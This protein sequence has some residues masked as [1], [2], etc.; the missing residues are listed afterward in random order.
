MERDFIVLLS[1]VC[2]YPSILLFFYLWNVILLFF[3]PWDV[4]TL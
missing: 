2:N 4:I 1:L 3:N